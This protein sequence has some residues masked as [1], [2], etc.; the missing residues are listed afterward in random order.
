MKG[1]TRQ[2][3]V[4]IVK[5]QDVY[6]GKLL[7]L[8]VDRLHLFSG[9]ELVREVVLHPPVAA[10]LPILPGGDILLVKQYRHP[11]GEMLWEIP[12]GLIDAGESPLA[13]AKSELREETG[14]EAREWVEVTSFFTSAGFTDEIVT[15]YE[16]SDLSLVGLPD[17]HE[18]DALKA[19]SL[20]A[21]TS[22]I[23]EGT[24]RDAKTII[25]ILSHRITYS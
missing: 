22:M 1:T 9:V 23:E 8:R 3:D 11:V 17:P 2:P 6:A 16:A 21:A 10:I 18:I 20:H 13:T 19:V 5:R 7:Q 4:R 24:I 25:A 12:A 14:Y 15:L